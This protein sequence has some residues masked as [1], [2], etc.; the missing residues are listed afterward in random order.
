MRR[1]FIMI[2]C[3]T[4]L[5]AA[6]AQGADRDGFALAFDGID[7]RIEIGDPV[8]VTGPL[9]LEAWV[10]VEGTNSGG[11]ILSNRS[12]ATGY[13]LDVSDD[14]FRFIING[15]VALSAVVGF[16]PERWLHV[17]VT[18]AGPGDEPDDGA[19]VMYVD[20]EPIASEKHAAAMNDALVDLKIGCMGHT[21]WYFQG[22]IDEPRIFAAV[23]DADDIR[24]W[25]HRR[26]A[27]DHPNYVD[28]RGAWSFE[29]G[30]GQVVASLVGSPQC[31]GHLGSDADPDVADPA[32]IASGMVAARPAS[33]SEVKSAFRP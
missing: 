26:I 15:N 16:D 28:M 2:V 18:W 32:W 9:T 20:G 3:G 29:E 27:A 24:T 13:E 11:R 25:M 31:D 7:D 14:R 22:A 6:V 19:V 33:W 10:R 30:A 17:A 8:N 5:V 12:G 23:V 4:V 21:G 1:S